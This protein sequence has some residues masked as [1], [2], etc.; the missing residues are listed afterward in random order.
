MFQYRIEKKTKSQIQSFE[1]NQILT[2]LFCIFQRQVVSRVCDQK[3]HL[4]GV[5]G[6]GLHAQTW[7]VIN[8]Q[9]KRELYTSGFCTGIH[10]CI[11]IYSQIPT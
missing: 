2:L 5:T 7:L 8:N 11:H 4:S 3:C 10:V 9:W 1:L 6:T